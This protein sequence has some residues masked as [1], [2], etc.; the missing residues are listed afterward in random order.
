MATIDLYDTLT[1]IEVLNGQPDPP[2]SFFL[3]RYFPQGQQKLFETEG[4]VFDQLPVN[5]RL[6]PFVAPNVQGRV[7]A[8]EG[9]ETKVFRP[10]YVKPKHVVNPS[11]AIPRQAGEALMGSMSLQER[12]DSIVAANLQRERDLIR[13]RNEWMAVQA[14]VN[15]S[16]TIASD[17]YPSVTIDFGR[18][19][20]LDVTL[21]GGATWDSTNTCDPLG[22]FADAR[23]NAR[24]YGRAI[25][26]DA[27]F[28][29]DAWNAFVQVPS[30][31]ETLNK[32]YLG[33]NSEFNTAI[34]TGEA[35][36][37][38]G[39]LQGPADAGNLKMWVYNEWYEDETADGFTL[40][41]D[42]DTVFLGGPNLKGY[43]TFGAIQDIQAG[44]APAEMWPK[45]WDNQDPSV[46]YTMT[47]SAPLP[48]PAWPNG[49]VKLKVIGG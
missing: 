23:T 35:I 40:Y 12:F 19:P 9:F 22:D 11:R 14:A 1:L 42:T 2:A 31:R 39:T 8:T 44:L 33:S 25:I 32:F 6:A 3:D 38:K 30:V 45:M 36:E 21:T 17:D 26:T 34:A 18:N 5:R 28:G 27:I 7:Q 41:L 10:A 43:R 15:A 47:Q 46:R 37:Y 29:Q 20:I 4:I 13:R 24:V 16:I 49:S 48:V